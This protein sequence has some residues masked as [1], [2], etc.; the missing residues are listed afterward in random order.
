M[1]GVVLI[2]RASTFVDLLF[3]REQTAEEAVEDA[4]NE[5]PGN[6]GNKDAGSEGDEGAGNVD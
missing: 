4:G 5:D 3:D 1:I 2:V 6:K